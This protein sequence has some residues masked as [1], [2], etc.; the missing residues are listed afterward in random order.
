VR[1]KTIAAV[2]SVIVLS[3]A[4]IASIALYQRM[5]DGMASLQTLIYGDR[6][7][8]KDGSSYYVVSVW[9]GKDGSAKCFQAIHAPYDGYQGEDH[10][11]HIYLADVSWKFLIG[12]QN[13]DYRPRLHFL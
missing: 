8:M 3:F 5:S 10:F 6:I 13:I 2:A 12:I 11:V 1:F 4:G 7:V 9:R